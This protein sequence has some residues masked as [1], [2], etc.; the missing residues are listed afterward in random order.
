MSHGSGSEEK[1]SKHGRADDA[2]RR[3][4]RLAS[5]C[6]IAWMALAE[7]GLA[8]AQSTAS[9]GGRSPAANAANAAATA[10][11]AGPVNPVAVLA[12]QL[13]ASRCFN[14]ARQVGEQV[15]GPNQSAGVVM[16]ASSGADQSLFST[17][18]E[19]RDGV[20]THF[21]SAFL[22]PNARG[23]CDGGYDD[24]RYWTKT[25]DQLLMEEM[26][27]LGAMRPLGPDIGTIVAGPNQH[28]YLMAAGPGCVS[29]RKELLY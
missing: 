20:G 23:G 6:L 14:M 24:V 17:S 12:G 7:P 18:I 2:W 26:R 19:T 27:G 21:V 22:T 13:N 15:V 8:G 10:S 28:V 1:R 16:A 25:C 5:A 29:I 9:P 11:A 3:R 4:A